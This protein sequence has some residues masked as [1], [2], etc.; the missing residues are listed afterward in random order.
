M[1][2]IAFGLILSNIVMLPRLARHFYEITT[3]S[4]DRHVINIKTESARAQETSHGRSKREWMQ[5]EHQAAKDM[6]V[7]ANN[8]KLRDEEA[9]DVAIDEDSIKRS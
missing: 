4:T 8:A 3:S 1:A 7:F 9:M 5:L 6:D 2:E